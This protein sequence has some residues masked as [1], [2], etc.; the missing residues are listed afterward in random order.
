MSNEAQPFTTPSRPLCPLLDAWNNA[1][2]TPCCCVRGF[3]SVIATVILNLKI[4]T[5]GDILQ[6]MWSSFMSLGRV[7]RNCSPTN[8]ILAGLQSSNS[9]GCLLLLLQ[10]AQVY[11]SC[12]FRSQK[13]LPEETICM[14]GA[15]YCTGCA[16]P[17]DGDNSQLHT[18]ATNA[19]F[20]GGASVLP[21]P[22][23]LGPAYNTSNFRAYVNVTVSAYADGPASGFTVNI[24]TLSDLVNL[25]GQ[26]YYPQGILFQ[27]RLHNCS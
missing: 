16:A 25:L 26:M 8:S 17:A 13:G 18:L 5:V 23:P 4:W 19:L 2:P 24:S 12:E 1:K 15:C 22:L 20:P 27:V 11:V 7:L 14:S 9:T 3:D 10:E 21:L 6:G